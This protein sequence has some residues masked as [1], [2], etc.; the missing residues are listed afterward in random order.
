MGG[1]HKESGLSK[2]FGG[3]NFCL[4]K[5]AQ[6]RAAMAGAELDMTG[7][8]MVWE[9]KSLPLRSLPIKESMLLLLLFLMRSHLGTGTVL[10]ASLF[11]LEKPSPFCPKQCV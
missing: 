9:A 5:A 4:L 6:V 1:C 11:R 2:F 8:D 7:V 10:P 3:S